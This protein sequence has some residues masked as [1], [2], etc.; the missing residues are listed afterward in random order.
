MRPRTPRHMR[1]RTSG[2]PF[3]AGAGS[4]IMSVEGGRLSSGRRDRSTATRTDKTEA[5]SPSGER[6]R[7][8]L[9]RPTA[10]GRHTIGDAAER[11]LD[12]SDIERARRLGRS[13]DEGCCEKLRRNTD[14][15]ELVIIREAGRK[16]LREVQTCRRLPARNA[17]DLRR[18][19]NVRSDDVVTMDMSKRQGELQRQ[20]GERDIDAAPPGNGPR[21]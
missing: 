4:L 5:T 1:G 14:P 12:I 16:L 9:K 3:A 15:A 21:Q 13:R 8:R 18:R 11:A 6:R 19:D 17:V 10:R 2:A 20:G 7:A